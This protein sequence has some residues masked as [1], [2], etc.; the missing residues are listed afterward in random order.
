MNTKKRFDSYV[1]IT[2]DLNAQY[3]IGAQAGGE[4]TDA[5]NILMETSE[6]HKDYE[7]Y[8]ATS[9]AYVHLLNARLRASKYFDFHTVD[10]YNV[11]KDEFKLFESDMTRL[12]SAEGN[13]L[14]TNELRIIQKN[15]P[16][17]KTTIELINGDIIKMEEHKEALDT[18][19]PAISA[20]TTQIKDSADRERMAFNKSIL[21]SNQQ[22]GVMVGS[23]FLAAILFG[24]FV[25]INILRSVLTP[26]NFLKETFENIASSEANTEFRL[27]VK[28]DDEIGKMS[29][30]FN[31]FM[32]KLKDM[33]DEVKY[34]NLLKT[35]ESDLA[36]MIRKEENL[37][38][39]SNEMIRYLC[40]HFD[41]LMGAI[42]LPT[43]EGRFNFQGAYAFVHK[44][45]SATEIE[46]GDGILGQVLKEHKIF[47]IHDLPEAYIK[48][49]SR[50]GE[51]PP[52]TIVAMPCLNEGELV[53]I[54]EMASFQDLSAIQ[55]SM[56][57]VL[58]EVVGRI[59]SN[60]MV[61]NQMRKLLEKTLGQAEELQVQQ[62]ELQQ[63]NEELEEQAR[64]LKESESQLQQQQEELRVSN[65]ELEAH[66][67]QL[68]DQKRVLNEKN[69]ALEQ[70][71]EIM[72]QKAD[73]L[74]MANRYKSEFLA[75]MSHELRTPLNSILVLSQ[76]LA[77]KK[78]SEPLTNKEKEFASTIHSSGKDLLTL[79][80]GVLDLSKV[81]AGKITDPS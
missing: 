59:L 72:S 28:S 29:L 61:R 9:D 25:I 60:V 81:E 16:R 22:S 11:Y 35:A 70:A 71:R 45:D 40:L 64:A 67:N 6:K 37:T 27:P 79:I 31:I 12:T 77:D 58:S 3:T 39:I 34:K 46:E 69:M 4:V 14:Y 20:L 41:M 47:V 8:A 51:A 32:V 33:M 7:V 49:Q 54:I 24:S 26:I 30:A 66:T 48:V 10:E 55:L 17:Y 52:K 74:E 13:M 43:V 76:L 68:E 73:D 38:V 80:N 62:E 2:D 23:I 18:I 53:G 15:T 5:M 56:L 75:N 36:E 19:G 78:A 21:A 50:L 42:Y 57:E 1:I 44:K 63:S 65:E